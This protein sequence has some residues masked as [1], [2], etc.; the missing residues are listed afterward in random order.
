M[1]VIA[2]RPVAG[3][4]EEFRAVD[5]ATG[6]ALEPAYRALSAPRIEEAVTAAATAFEVYRDTTPQQ[7]AA[8]LRTIADNLDARRDALVERA[9]V[10]TGLPEARLTGEVG[11]TSGQLRLMADEVELGEHQGV[12]I[13]HA[14]PDRSPAPAPDLRLR[15]IPIGPV[16]VFGASNFPFA[17]ST[18]GGD[19]AAA[20]AA[21][22]PVIV[23]A[24]N[25]HPGTAELAA[26][27]IA[28]AVN[29]CGLPP[30]TFSLLYGVGNEI[31]EHLVAHPD[32]RGVGFTGSRAGGLALL[33][34]AQARPTPIP[35]Y[36]EMSSINPV[37]VLP[38][39]AK[40]V[41]EVAQ[42]YL[43]SLT[44]GS[45]QFCTN[46][47][48]LFVPEE[49]AELRTAIG[50]AVGETRG[51]TMLTEPISDAY[52]DGVARLDSIDVLGRGAEGD[53]PNAPAPVVAAVTT[54]QL[55][56][57]PGLAD[58]VFGAASL[59]VSYRDL[60][61]VIDTLDLL[62]GQ[63]TVS[64]HV[65]PSDHEALR[66]LLPTLE[67]LAGRIIVNAW[68][69][70]VEVTHAMVHGGPF[71][72]TSDGR[73]T[74]VGTLAITRFQRPVSYQGL[75]EDLLPQAIRDENPYGLPRRVDGTLE[76]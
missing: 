62:E 31:G 29:S 12:R 21:G 60:E 59:V 76:R 34:I 16:V 71:P 45:G 15:S 19:T 51:Q 26:G 66:T 49:A 72:A 37:I 1:S 9:L 43:G 47:G 41:D 24:H 3:D 25:A 13:D 58:E 54:A 57:T 63:L 61:D 8:F 67:D 70:G 17:F 74:S 23:K 35:V 56:D 38:G 11:R 36:A 2:G 39:R 48:L 44:L 10:E 42:G 65:E 52:R 4:G 20:L 22:C 28:D 73:S 68:P 27:A 64:V 18:A 75:P 55:R 7:R 33:R 46:P 53:G 40:A 50:A 30:G 14:Q 5:P 69:T 6:T 32:V